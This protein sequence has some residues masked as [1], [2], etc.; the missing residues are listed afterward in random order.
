[1]HHHEIKI[2]T[3]GTRGSYRAVWD[4]DNFYTVPVPLWSVTKFSLLEGAY[5]VS[6]GNDSTDRKA[7]TDAD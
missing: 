7:K 1:M 5:P 2:K 3:F 6:E 4:Y